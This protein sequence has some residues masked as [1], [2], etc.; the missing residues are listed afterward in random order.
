MSSGSKYPDV[1][2]PFTDESPASWVQRFCARH[3]CSITN[4]KT[5]L[6][7]PTRFDLDTDLRDADWVRLDKLLGF[8]H[9]WHIHRE[10]LL[11]R[12]P[13]GLKNCSEIVRKRPYGWCSSCFFGEKEPYF[14]WSW[15]AGMGFCPVHGRRLQFEC[16]HCGAPAGLTRTFHLKALNM[17]H[18][19]SCG[20]W[21]GI[22]ARRD[23]EL[24][25][26]SAPRGSENRTALVRTCLHE[27]LGWLVG[28]GEPVETPLTLWLGSGPPRSNPL[29]LDWRQFV[30]PDP[31]VVR[32]RKWSL[33]FPRGSVNRSRLAA[34]LLLLRSEKK[35]M[36]LADGQRQ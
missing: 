24:D 20:K 2:R 30:W 12:P 31:R 36:R 14:R 6:G 5:V 13:H 26:R 27:K 25:R 23:A 3:S 32:G 9:D 19:Q 16:E 15:R 21:L 10:R 34:A 35:S 8:G 18:C 1:P 33:A 17:A 4:F 22:A 7:V 11:L 29:R 28:G